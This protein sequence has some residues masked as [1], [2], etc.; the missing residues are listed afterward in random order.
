MVYKFN[1]ECLSSLKQTNL[2]L[3]LF[4]SH[5]SFMLSCH[6]TQL[7]HCLV[8][9]TP[10]LFNIMKITIVLCST[11]HYTTRK[12]TTCFKYKRFRLD[13]ILLNG[14]FDKSNK[15]IKGL[16]FSITK[17]IVQPA[18]QKEMIATTHTHY[19]ISTLPPFHLHTHYFQPFLSLIFEQRICFVF[20]QSSLR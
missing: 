10:R 16:I 20:R 4:C 9:S 11:Y 3:T 5:Q 17:K 7:S 8:L 19:S 6:H 15:Y 2:Y 12:T 14:C 18:Q 1:G 13:F